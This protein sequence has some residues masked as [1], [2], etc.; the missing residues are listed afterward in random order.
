MKAILL[1]DDEPYIIQGLKR[2][3]DL[4]YLESIDVLKRLTDW[5]A[6]YREIELNHLMVSMLL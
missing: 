2:M 4:D 1:V 5:V 6:D 3:L